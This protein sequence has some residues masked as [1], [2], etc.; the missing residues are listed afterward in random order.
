MER[1]RNKKSILD[2]DVSC[3]QNYNT[4]SNPVTVNLLTW[5]TSNQYRKDVEQIRLTENKSDRDK[6]KS[7]LPAVTPS[8]VFSYRDQKSL[9]QHS[10]LIQFDIDLKENNHIRNFFE[11]KQ[12][13]SNIPNVAYCGLSVSGQGFWG[14]IP[15]AYTD[16]HSQHFES[17]RKSFL[18]FGIAI[19]VKPKN[20]CSLRGYSFD[21]EPYINHQASVCVRYEFHRQ[22]KPFPPYK[23]KAHIHSTASVRT[24][25]EACITEI[26][27]SKTDITSSYA[28]WFEIG[29]SFVAEFGEDGRK[30]FHQVS[31]F[32]PHYSYT[33]TNMQFNNCINGSYSFSIG[34][35][36]R[37]CKTHFS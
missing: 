10:G 8:G 27:R 12:Q 37:H 13:I 25:V 11:L 32:H 28:A 21:P 7:R 29:C 5:L 22:P 36:F 23:F 18:Q 19:D 2:V 30:Y 1:N 33:K 4:P 26:E 3:F 35:F 14:L 15:I 16:R 20:V 17:I 6:L 31:Q 34:T 24:K 9:I